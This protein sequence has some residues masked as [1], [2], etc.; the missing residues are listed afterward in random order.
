MHRHVWLGAIAVWL[1][2]AV[3]SNA[4]PPTLRELVERSA[5]SP[6]AAAEASPPTGPPAHAEVD[7][8]E[9]PVA[10]SQPSASEGETR[11]SAP[12]D[13]LGRDTPRG[14]LEGLLRAFDDRDFERAAEYLDLRSVPVSE[15]R[16]VGPRLAEQ[17]QVVLAHTVWVDPEALSDNP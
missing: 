13:A 2:S 14:T 9:N 3:A 15:R 6:A 16:M 5:E 1:C 10:R 4:A 7:A 8:K 12:Q 17:L 11:P